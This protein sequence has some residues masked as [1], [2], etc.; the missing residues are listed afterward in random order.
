MPEQKQP[1]TSKQLQIIIQE[2]ARTKCTELRL[3]DLGISELPD[4]IGQLVNLRVLDLGHN[5]LASLPESIGQ[6][7]NL[8]KLDLGGNQLASLHASIGQLANLQLLDLTGNG[9]A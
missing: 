6:L 8:Q 4:E 7:D 3:T 5:H 2:A 1:I 9:E